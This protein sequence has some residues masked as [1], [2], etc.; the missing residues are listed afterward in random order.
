MFDLSG[1]FLVSVHGGGDSGGIA[2][3]LDDFLIAIENLL[4]LSP[5][6]MFAELLPGIAAM[7]NW[8]PLFVHFPIALLT[9][10]FLIDFAGSVTQKTEWRVT[11]GWFL[12]L[13]TIFA[14]ITMTFGLIAAASV[15]HGDDVHDIMETHEHFGIT[16]FT[17]S[18]FL[19]AWRLIGKTALQGVANY[20]YLFFAGLLCV[21]LVFAADL[22]GLMVYKH[23]VAVAAAKLAHVEGLTERQHDHEHSHSH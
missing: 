14:G 15:L 19:S 8:H 5:E 22:G 11:A 18:V 13:G 20:L 10:F 21:L 4:S 23:G 6:E 2:G 3:L 12:Y 16:I 9:M 7:E 1:N 17:L